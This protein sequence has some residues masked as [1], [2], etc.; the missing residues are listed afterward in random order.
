[1]YILYYHEQ[2]YDLKIRAKSSL[3]IACTNSF[4]CMIEERE[5]RK[6]CIEGEKE[7]NK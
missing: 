4:D 6:T 3:I 2:I 7:G 5:K 1:M